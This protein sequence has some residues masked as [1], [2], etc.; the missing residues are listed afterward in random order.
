[1]GFKKNDGVTI[2]INRATPTGLRIGLSANRMNQT[3]DV[4]NDESFMEGFLAT[5]HS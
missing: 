3:K 5:I 1:M 4:G 2:A